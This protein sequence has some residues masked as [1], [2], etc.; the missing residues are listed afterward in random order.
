MC[1]VCG[2]VVGVVLRAADTFSSLHSR[3]EWR[4][5]PAGQDSWPN[6]TNLLAELDEPLGL[7][8]RQRLCREETIFHLWYLK[9]QVKKSLNPC[10][11][12]SHRLSLL[13]GFPL[14]D[15]GNHNRQVW[16]PSWS[17]PGKNRLFPSKP[18]PL[19]KPL[20]FVQF[21]QESCPVGE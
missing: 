8:Q 9:K 14:Y 6:W 11:K 20:R 17:T 21:G 10:S 19:C 15:H 4:Y 18:L 13:Q 5:S 12:D 2:M 1:E 3:S 7:D 16:R